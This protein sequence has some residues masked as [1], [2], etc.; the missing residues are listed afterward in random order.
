MRSLSDAAA[1]GTYR[2]TWIVGPIG[3]AMKELFCLEIDEQVFS[4]Q[5]S[6]LEALCHQPGAD[7]RT[8]LRQIVPTFHPESAGVPAQV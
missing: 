3:R 8:M 5:L 1:G 6:Q 7:V 4:E 2:I